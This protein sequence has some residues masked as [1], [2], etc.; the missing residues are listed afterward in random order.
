MKKIQLLLIAIIL[1]FTLSAKEYHVAKTGN[2]KNPGT[3]DKPLLTIQ[4][5][6]NIAQPGDIITV[7][8]G[9]YRERIT[10]PRGGESDSKRIIYEAEKGETVEIKGSE[11]IKN[12]E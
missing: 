1:G 3:K 8:E 10:P 6:A 5:A 9:I 12:W 2:D 7:H 4:A 11:I